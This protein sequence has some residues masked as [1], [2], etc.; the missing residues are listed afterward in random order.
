MRSPVFPPR[1]F[2][3]SRDDDG[4]TDRGAVWL[5][6]TPGPGLDCDGEIADNPALDLNGNGVLDECECFVTTNCQT[7]PNSV[8]PGATIGAIGQ[9][10]ISTENFVLTAH[11]C[12]ASQFGVFP[13]CGTRSTSTPSAAPAATRCAARRPSPRRWRR[14]GSRGGS[15]SS[16]RSR[17]GSTPGSTAR[18][19]SS[20][21]SRSGR[22]RSAC[23]CGRGTRRSCSPLRKDGEDVGERT[24]WPLVVAREGAANLLFAP[25][26]FRGSQ[27][28]REPVRGDVAF[29]QIIRK[30]RCEVRVHPARASP[31]TTFVGGVEKIECQE[32]D[33]AGG[34]GGTQPSQEDTRRCLGPRENYD[35]RS[36]FPL[37][38]ISVATAMTKMVVLL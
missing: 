13:S 12:P 33:I 26:P 36:S 2:G 8:G 3:A 25:D 29:V 37:K 30:R 16:G 19:S 14:R 1:A 6:S 18:P 4:G 31:F 24:R 9:P 21:V 32:G 23:R 11:D 10:L 27:R 22:R 35:P 5:L 20:T 38:A 17:C 15:S 28:L 34:Y 7:S